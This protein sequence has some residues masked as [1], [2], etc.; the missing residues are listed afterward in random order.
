MPAAQPP[1]S[2]H[3]TLSAFSQALSSLTAPS[4]DE[5]LLDLLQGDRAI[6][7][8]RLTQYRIGIALNQIKAMALAY[9]VVQSLIGEQA[10][11]ALIQA[12]VQQHPSRSGNLDQLGRALPAFLARFE[13]ALEHAYLPDVAQLEWAVH[14]AYGAADH[15]GLSAAEVFGGVADP[16]LVQLSLQPALAVLEAPVAASAL[17]TWSK[18]QAE[19]PALPAPDWQHAEAVVVYRDEHTVRVQSVSVAQA[20]WLRALQAGCSLA[21]ACDAASAEPP[22]DLGDS[23]SMAFSLGWVACAATLKPASNPAAR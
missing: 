19:D 15:R 20:R 8:R 17:W 21:Q 11:A 23:L 10:F 4:A 14:Q 6:N 9:P 13:P 22:L 7:L 2:L 12:Y 3:Q 16:G 1:A 5:A 18:A